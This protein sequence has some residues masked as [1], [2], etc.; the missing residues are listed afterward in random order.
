MNNHG[1]SLVEFCNDTKSSIVNGRI[2]PLTDNFTWISTKGI[3]VVDY[4]LKRHENL[5]NV[6]DFTVLTI[7]NIIESI[8]VHEAAASPYSI[9]NHSALVMEIVTCDVNV[10][11][12][13]QNSNTSTPM[14]G[15]GAPGASHT[16]PPWFKVTVVQNDFLNSEE[17]RNKLLSIIEDIEKSRKTQDDI[18]R[19]Y[20]ESYDT[21]IQEMGKFIEN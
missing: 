14:N 1:E 3:A 15:H 12:S 17:S 13:M 8:G 19:I 4:F 10:C 16:R 7:T 11:E 18:D 2:S 9:T 6:L 20:D 5:K 21:Y